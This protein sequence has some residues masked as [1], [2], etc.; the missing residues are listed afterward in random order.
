MEDYVWIIA[1]II[2]ALLWG[3]V[4]REILN[5]KG[6]P[7]PDVGWAWGIFF[8]F[9]GAI[10]CATKPNL[11]DE[12]LKYKQLYDQGVITQEEF[13]VKKRELLGR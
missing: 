6:Y 4:C 7:K 2:W 1:V 5:N 8:G 12:L 10:I 13:D 9:L 3:G 11:N